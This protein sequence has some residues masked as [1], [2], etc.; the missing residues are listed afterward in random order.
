VTK[1]YDRIGNML[2]QTSEITHYEKGFSV[3]QLGNMSYGAGMGRI[4]RIGRTAPYR[5]RNAGEA[6]S[7]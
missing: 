3:T 4:S 2:A 1:I 6:R 7:N 5:A